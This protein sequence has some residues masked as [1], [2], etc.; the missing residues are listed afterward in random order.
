MSKGEELTTTKYLIY[1]EINANGIVEKPDVVGA[2]FGQTEGL[3]SNDLDLRELQRTG[4]IGRIQVII[5]SN[6]GRAKGEIVIPSSLDRIE[7]AILAASL[8]TINRV[9]PC[10]ANIKVKKVEDV[11]AVKRQQVVERA[12]E[13]YQGMM[14]TVTPASMQMIEEVREAMRVH[15]ISEFGEERLPAGPSVHTSDAIIVVEGRNDVLNLLKYGIKNTVAVEGVN[16]PPVIADL[17]KKRTVTAFVDGDRGGELILKE[18]IQVGDVDFVTRAPVGKEVEDLEKDEVITALRDKTPIEQFLASTNLLSV[19]DSPRNKSKKSKSR[20]NHNN[21]KYN[22]RNN[23]HQDDDYGYSDIVEEPDLDDELE[24][25]EISLMK[26]M[27][28]EIEGSGTGEILDGALN[29]MKEVSVE[30]LYNEVQNVEDNAETIVF[31]GIVSQ[32]LVDA[33]YKK[34]IKNLVAFKASNIVKKPRDV[35]IITL[36]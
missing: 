10:E 19:Q 35:K 15:E 7:T 12:K 2:I 1:A 4:R 17:T 26:D 27:L 6:S 16:V 11:R 20:N 28:R 3:L 8:E 33:S 13:I 34:G 30:D 5:H 14:D 22:K 23:R 32:R 18:L 21:K 36:H 31:D 29:L 9:G 24:D 25:D